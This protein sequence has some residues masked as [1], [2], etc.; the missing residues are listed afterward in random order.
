MIHRQGPWFTIEIKMKKKINIVF[1]FIA[2]CWIVSIISWIASFDLN[3][4]GIH[5]RHAGGMVGILFSPFFHGSYSHLVVNTVPLF[6]LSIVLLFFYEKIAFLVIMI[7]WIV[8][9]GLTWALARSGIHIGASGLIYGIA[10]FL[11]S[12]GILKRNFTS[13]V[14]SVIITTVYGGS[15]VA[16][17]L[18][19]GVAVS[20]EGHLFSAVSGV[21]AG[22]LLK[23]SKP[24]LRRL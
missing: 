1:F 11:I 22:V 15:M 20:W 13:I 8:G 10:A 7:V 24:H 4:L 23:G 18:P 12:F 2:M 14:I 21:F 16:S 17:I 6:V 19:T 9:G 5:P 3:Y